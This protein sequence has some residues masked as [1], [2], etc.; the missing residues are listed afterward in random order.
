MLIGYYRRGQLRYAGKV[1]T[2][3]NH[4][5]LQS[6]H[7][8]FLRIRSDECPFSDLPREH[9]PHFGTG[10][11]RGE[12]RKVTWLQP[13]LVAQIKFAEWTH[14]AILRQ[15][16]FLGLRRDKAAREVRREAFSPHPARGG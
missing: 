13:E 5:L 4:R 15:P 3:F 9:K 1:G 8:K 11:T 10:M 7:G 2:G 6:L 14:D 12:M 16:V